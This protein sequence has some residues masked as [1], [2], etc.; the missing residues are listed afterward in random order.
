[1]IGLRIIILE[2]NIKMDIK[3]VR[4]KI[5]DM[6]LN[7]YF[8]LKMNSGGG[9]TC[10]HT[11]VGK[12]ADYKIRVIVENA[13]QSIEEL[14]Q[15]TYNPIGGLS[16]SIEICSLKNYKNVK[17]LLESFNKP[18]NSSNI[19][20][21]KIHF[22]VYEFSKDNK[23]TFFIRKYNKIQALK[24]GFIGHLL[25][26]KFDY[27]QTKNSLG[28]DVNLDVIIEDDEIAIINHISFERI[29][30]LKDEFFNTAEKVLNDSKL[31]KK[32]V[33]YDKFKDDA[34]N[35]LSYVK[36]ISKLISKDNALVF[37]DEIDKTKKVIEEFGLGIRINDNNQFLYDEKSQLGDFVNLMQDAYY[38]TLIGEKKGTDERR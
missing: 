6:D 14:N 4:S 25:N 7:I 38:K 1:M 28:I 29:F 16:D 15:T 17:D 10:F 20:S 30:N 13:L 24:K 3:N 11:K 37:L 23:K 8:C 34:L 32:I 18:G 31:Q 9:F 2:E 21:E 19:Q 5:V 27:L 33:N 35:N 22:I 12:G 36:R 26:N